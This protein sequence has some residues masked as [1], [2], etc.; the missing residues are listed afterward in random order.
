[1]KY[2]YSPHGEDI[3]HNYY[4]TL[5]LLFQYLSLIQQPQEKLDR[6]SAQNNIKI[7]STF[8]VIFAQ[9]FNALQN[10]YS[11]CVMAAC[12]TVC[13]QS[14]QL[15]EL[16]VGDTNGKLLVYKND[17]SKPWITRTCVGMVR[18]LTRSL[19]KTFFYFIGG[20]CFFYSCNLSLFSSLPVLQLGTSATKER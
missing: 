1:M 17:D 15:N 10:D 20:V 6:K 7:K 16:V 13:L 2:I 11:L 8:W 3:V 9:R 18:K 4:T 12:I 14:W 5:Q 19:G